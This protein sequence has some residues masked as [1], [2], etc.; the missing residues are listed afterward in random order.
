[1]VSIGLMKLFFYFQEYMS[2]VYSR[3]AKAQEITR[4][5]VMQKLYSETAFCIT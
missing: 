5:F 2:L 4:N 3:K 1:M